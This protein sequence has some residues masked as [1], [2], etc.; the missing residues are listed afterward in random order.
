MK[1]ILK[2]QKGITLVSLAVAIVILVIITNIL[3]YNAKDNA[4]I[5]KLKGMNNDVDNLTDKVSAYYSQ[6]GEL[7]IIKKA[8]YDISGKS[9]ASDESTDYIPGDA[10]KGDGSAEYDYYVIDL[11]LLSGLTLNYGADFE[12]INKDNLNDINNFED[13]YIINNSSHNIFYVKGVE[14]D[15]KK[16]YTS[17]KKDNTEMKLK[18]R[19]I[20]GVKIPDGAVY[21]SGHKNTSDLKIR[22]TATNKEYK[23]TE[24]KEEIT[25]VPADVIVNDEYEFLASA[26]ANNGYYYKD[27]IS[28]DEK[29]EFNVEYLPLDYGDNYWTGLTEEGYYYKDK[30]GDKAYIPK[31]FSVSMTPN[32]NTIYKGLVVKDSKNNEYVWIN[33]PK[34]MLE[35]ADTDEEI[36]NILKDYAKDY[37][38]EGYEDVWYDGCG[39][40]EPEYKELKSKMLTSIKEHG[41]FYIGRYETGTEKEKIE[42]S[43]N[44]S[45]ALISKNQYPYVCISLEQAETVSKQILGENSEIKTGLMFGIQWE[46]VCKFLEVTGSLTKSEIKTDS[47][48]WGNYSNAENFKVTKGYY[49][50]EGAN[51]WTL[52]SGTFT[53]EKGKAIALSSGATERNSKL[54]IY[55]FVGNM[56]EWTLQKS[57]NENYP[58]TIMAGDYNNY[59]GN[60]STAMY[61]LNNSS[62]GGLSYCY[63]VGFRV[64]IY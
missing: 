10:D 19:Y 27:P 2:N 8:K 36:E 44:T 29:T 11:K 51:S 15:D 16:Y 46:L 31:G 49:A 17:Q 22:I 13:L 45:K 57:N 37:R 25:T 60:I 21:L 34:N 62:M 55:D 39:L 54:N 61:R 24:L 6:Y 41:G 35:D 1:K 30:N 50:N 38:Q 52:I 7:P 64:A 20:D 53:K 3:V 32:M 23:W 14:V 28:D 43:E 63:D 42:Y 48:N 18:L 26:N 33:V 58:Q 40:S 59:T 9:I 12:A 47:T 4:Y 5:K 56:W